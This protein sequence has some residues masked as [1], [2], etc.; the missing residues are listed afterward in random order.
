[1]LEFNPNFGLYIPL[2]SLKIVVFCRI[3]RRAGRLIRRQEHP[4]WVL[5]EKS[6]FVWMP[7]GES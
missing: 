1:M 6:D 5:T 7:A 4:T 2:I 3:R